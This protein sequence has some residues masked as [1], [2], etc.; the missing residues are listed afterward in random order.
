MLSI[1]FFALFSVVK[2]AV[3]AVLKVAISALSFVVWLLSLPFHDK[4][5]SE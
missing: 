1:I 4:E 3:K 2:F 5:V